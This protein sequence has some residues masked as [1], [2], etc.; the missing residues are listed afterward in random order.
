MLSKCFSDV[1]GIIF[2]NLENF[3]KTQ[4]RPLS[5]FLLC[6]FPHMFLT[7]PEIDLNKVKLFKK[8][9]PSNI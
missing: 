6:I 2:K 4:N 9:E 3:K 8:F 1:I 5:G 7:K